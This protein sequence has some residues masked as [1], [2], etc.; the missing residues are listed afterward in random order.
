MHERQRRRHLVINEIVT[1]ERDYVRDLQVLLS[2]FMYA[3]RPSF[4]FV[5]FVLFISSFFPRR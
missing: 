2:V 5:S 3:T 4:F 1:T